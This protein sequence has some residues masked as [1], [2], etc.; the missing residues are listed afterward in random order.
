MFAVCL[1]E[2]AAQSVGHSAL[3]H[4][5]RQ[6]IVKSP[7]ERLQI[8]VHPVLTDAENHSPVVVRRL[9][10]QQVWDLFTLTRAA[11]AAWSPDD[12]RIL[13]IDQPTADSYQV[14]L[15]SSEGQKTQ[16]DTDKM[17]RSAVADLIG[18]KRTIEFYLPTL[19]SWEGHELVLAVGGTSS[20]GI[21]KPMK[22]YCFGVR[23]DDK[24]GRVTTFSGDVLKR[25]FNSRCR[26]NP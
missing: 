17:I 14:H 24:S 26:I 25:Q 11:E 13:V 20:H 12:Q 4:W 22:P 7:D 5:S 1:T 18:R 10:D 8:E 2:L 15:F 6:T 9:A 3:L 16:V 19:V 23:V 21:N